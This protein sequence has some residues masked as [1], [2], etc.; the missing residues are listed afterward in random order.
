[1]SKGKKR[2]KIRTVVKSKYKFQ[3]INELSKYDKRRQRRQ[4]LQVWEFE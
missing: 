1:M 2:N 3:R 4:Y